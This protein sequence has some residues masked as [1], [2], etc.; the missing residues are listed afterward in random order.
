MSDISKIK[1][2][3]TT[4]DIKDQVGRDA[5]TNSKITTVDSTSDDDHIPTAK[6]AYDYGQVVKNDIMGAMVTTISSAS[7][8]AHYPSAKAVYDYG[9]TLGGSGGSSGGVGTDELARELLGTTVTTI[10]GFSNGDYTN[11]GSLTSLSPWLQNYYRK[12][13]SYVNVSN[14]QSNSTHWHP[15]QAMKITLGS[16]SDLGSS[17]TSTEDAGL[18]EPTYINESGVT[19]YAYVSNIT[20]SN[21]P[22]VI[23]LR[24]SVTITTDGASITYSPG[25]YFYNNVEQQKFVYSVDAYYDCGATV[26]S[27]LSWLSTRTTD[28]ET[29]V[30]TLE[31]QIKSQSQSGYN[32]DDYYAINTVHVIP[33]TF[34]EDTPHFQDFYKVSDV[35]SVEGVFHIF[36]QIENDTV[37]FISPLIDFSG[38][39]GIPVYACVSELPIFM[40]VKDFVY[41]EEVT[42]PE[43]GEVTGTKEVTVTPGLY[44]IPLEQTISQLVKKEKY[45]QQKSIPF[46]QNETPILGH[47]YKVSDDTNI[48]GLYSVLGF[49][50]ISDNGAFSVSYNS[51]GKFKPISHFEP[52]MAIDTIYCLPGFYQPE[53][54]AAMVVTQETTIPANSVGNSEDFIVEPGT[55]LQMEQFPHLELVKLQ[56]KEEIIDLDEL[57]GQVSESGTLLETL[58][59]QLDTSETGATTLDLDTTNLVEGTNVKELYHKFLTAFDNNGKIKLK[60][61][62]NIMVDTTFL[63]DAYLWKTENDYMHGA[64]EATMHANG[65]WIKLNFQFYSNETNFGVYSRASIQS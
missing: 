33:N 43:T 48:N 41:P 34:T 62:G 61:S 53:L 7:D 11:T 1:V 54:L 52:E 5:F 24:N 47:Y 22:L 20:G 26:K 21:F 23:D 64:I 16:P 49:D 35:F 13:D 14:G 4:Y 10:S 27:A 12:A 37:D 39:S 18:I 50:N 63:I 6:A 25:L 55:Y 46:V 42:D 19:F 59:Q 15:I 56:E 8:D 58:M 51:G 30:T 31:E 2:G 40:V 3:E 28:V 9:Q 36:T 38:L 32:L 45:I 17:Y 65:M 60:A 44:C 57:F 29:K